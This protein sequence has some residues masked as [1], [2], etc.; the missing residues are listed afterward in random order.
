MALTVIGTAGWTIPAQHKPEFTQS[1]THLE[2]YV[3]KFNDVEINSSF[4]RPH[5]RKTYERWADS[6][7]GWLPVLSRRFLAA[8]PTT[9]E[10]LRSYGG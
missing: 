6:V 1:G 9:M 8:S 3:A 7:P 5:Q 10:H 2:R 4:Y